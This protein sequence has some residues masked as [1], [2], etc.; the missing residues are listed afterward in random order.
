[1][2]KPKAKVL[3]SILGNHIMV[4]IRT[5]LYLWKNPGCKKYFKQNEKFRDRYNGKRCFI[6]GN[7]PSLN[8]VD[9]S[10][11]RDEY[12]FTVNQLSRKK[13][14]AKLCTNFHMWVDTR[15]FDL[16]PSDESDME[17]L[18]TMENVNTEGNRP[19]VFYKWEAYEAVKKFHLDEKL[20]IHF[21]T[22]VYYEKKEKMIKQKLSFTKFVPLL[23]S[24][25]QYAVVLAVY[26]GFKEIYLLGCD[27]T[28]FINLVVPKLQKAEKSEYAYDISD[29]EKKRLEKIFSP[30]DLR[31]DLS[32]YVNLFDTYEILGKYCERNGVKLFNATENSLLDCLPRVNLMTVLGK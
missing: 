17:L 28:G 26:M 9:F 6:F 21:F 30:R 1:M 20:D 27:C 29:N 25:T 12:T 4:Y 16:D 3:K 7:G 10:L 31:L 18:Q 15:F 8:N 2:P 13:D 5:R 22:D 11:L 24:V 14:F 23:E 19:V 32:S